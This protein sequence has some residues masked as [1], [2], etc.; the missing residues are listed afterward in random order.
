MSDD[1]RQ[2]LK[3]LLRKAPKS[4]PGSATFD[5]GEHTVAEVQEYLA[6]NPGDTDRVLKA[7][8]KGKARATLTG[9]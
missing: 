2:Q 7:E 1:G 3:N 4:S 9:D 6:A 8:R 5:P